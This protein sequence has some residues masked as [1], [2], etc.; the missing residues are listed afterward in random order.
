M[1]VGC[2]PQTGKPEGRAETTSLESCAAAVEHDP[3]CKELTA[4]LLNYAAEELS[5]NLSDIV[6][7]LKK[8]APPAGESAAEPGTPTS[9]G[10]FANTCGRKAAERPPAPLLEVDILWPG[11]GYNSVCCG[12]NF[13]VLC[14]LEK[15]GIMKVHDVCGASGGACS[16]ILALADSDNSSRTLIFYYMVY[17]KWAEI[18]WDMQVWQATSLWPDIYRKCIEDDGA[19]GRVSKRGYCAVAAGKTFKNVVMHNFK[20]KD[21]VVVGFQASGEASVV[22]AAR[23]LKVDA[24]ADKIGKCSDG[25]NVCPFPGRKRK[26]LYYHTFYGYALKCTLQTIEI[27]YKKGVDE[28][29]RLLKSQDLRIATSSTYLQ[30]M[31]LALNG[32]GGMFITAGEDC[33]KVKQKTMIRPSG[34]FLNLTTGKEVPWPPKDPADIV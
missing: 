16:T 30:G 23:G 14:L 12:G 1:D 9:R 2:C 6:S 34:M 17:A 27:L 32:E 28:T 19:F 29:I 7:N 22:G 4:K 15:K 26:V 25:G 33:A 8:L 18:S 24:A 21:Q 3:K 13:E 10:C 5:K 20:S 11:A 31:E